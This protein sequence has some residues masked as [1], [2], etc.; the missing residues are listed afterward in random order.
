VDRTDFAGAKGAQPES[1]SA[2][3]QQGEVETR[4]YKGATYVKG[5]D[6]EWCLQKTQSNVVNQE[7]PVAA[8]KMPASVAQDAALRA[9]QLEAE[10]QPALAKAATG[11]A[12]KPAPLAKPA[13][14]PPAK[15]VA[16]PPVKAAP[17]LPAK[18]VAKPPVKAAQK[19]PA[20]APAKTSAPEPTPLKKKPAPAL[21][22]KSAKAAGPAVKKA[23]SKPKQAKKS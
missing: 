5:A 2:P 12:R 14:K 23:A 19:P 4:T 16:K 8:W 7:T 20:K 10:S 22:P 15:A 6:G 18:A 9:T 21:L 3:S 1:V 13:P 11:R 17:K